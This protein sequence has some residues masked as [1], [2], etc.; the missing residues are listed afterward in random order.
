[1]QKGRMLLFFLLSAALP[2]GAQTKTVEALKGES[3]IT[4]H[5]NHPLHHIT[6]VSKD[7]WFRAELDP[8]NQ[9]I[10]NVT[11]QVDVMTFD[12]GNSN[13]DSH[14]M[15]VIESLKYPDVTF[16]GAVIKESGDSIRVS[17]QLTFHGVTSS[18]TMAGTAKWSENQVDVSGDFDIS[19]T[20]FK[21]ER[22]S[23]L[24]LPVDD[25]LRFSVHAVFPR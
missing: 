16:A 11:A 2:L 18:I 9:E 22:P 19:L 23:L 14:A 13:R 15:E 17:G 25:D 1:M 21:V 12:S 5:L 20:S 10:K 4:Y 8:A 7:G 24:M 6:A 3:N